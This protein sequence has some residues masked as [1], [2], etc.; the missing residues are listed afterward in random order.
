MMVKD[1]F[2]SIQGEG[3]RS[4]E[5]SIFIRLSG[6]NLNCPFCDTDYTGGVDMSLDEIYNAIKDY[7]CDWIVWTGGE[8]TLQLTEDIIEYFKLNGFKQAIESN[9]TKP[10][11][12]GIDYIVASP[13]GYYKMKPKWVNELRIP[14]SC[15]NDI[16]KYDIS[17]PP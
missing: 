8:P 13:K 14:V 9:G 17:L 4:G 11:P 2:Y 16:S 1:I 3:A 7:S 10:I 12:K 6:C 15:G 5:A